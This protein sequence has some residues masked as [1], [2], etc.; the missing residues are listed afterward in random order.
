GDVIEEESQSINVRSN[1]SSPTKKSVEFAAVNETFHDQNG[2][3][4]EE[5]EDEGDDGDNQ[6]GAYV[7]HWASDDEED[8][9]DESDQADRQ[10]YGG[11]SSGFFEER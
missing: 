4:G 5:E 2:S 7:N 3:T 11:F 1:E 6:E 8:D 9:E 10:E